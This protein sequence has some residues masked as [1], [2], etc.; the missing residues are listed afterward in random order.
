MSEK[1]RPVTH[2]DVGAVTAS[3]WRNERRD[4]PLY[5]TTFSHRYKDQSGEWH[6]TASFSQ[7]DL[8]ALQKAADLAYDAIAAFRSSDKAD[9]ATG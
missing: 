5:T 6:T 8:L 3:I 9:T 2:I 7:M 1:Q 4:Q